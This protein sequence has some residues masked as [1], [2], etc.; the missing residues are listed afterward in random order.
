VLYTLSLWCLYQFLFHHHV[1]LITGDLECS[2]KLGNMIPPAFFFFFLLNV[3]GYSWSFWVHMVYSVVQ[4]CYFIFVF[5]HDDISIIESQVLRS[6]IIT[7]LLFTSTFSFVG[8]CF[9]YVGATML[10]TYIFTML[11]S[12]E[13]T[14]LSFYNYFLSLMTSFCLKV[15]FVWYKYRNPC[16]SS[17]IICME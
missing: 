10:G 14:L 4:I 15:Y 3:V 11:A 8:I 5:C 16:S 6:A 12:Y 7:A 9:I 17:F 13:L 1:V 2:L